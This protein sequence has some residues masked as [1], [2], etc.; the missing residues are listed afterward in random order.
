MPACT[1]GKR[2]R[3][4]HVPLS[5]SVTITLN[6]C[7][8][9]TVCSIFSV[10]TVIIVILPL[11]DL[12]LRAAKPGNRRTQGNP[13]IVSIVD[14]AFR[15]TSYRVD[16]HTNEYCRGNCL[17]VFRIFYHTHHHVVISL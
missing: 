16:R 10:Y 3:V 5:K 17:V 9:A 2:D 13:N 11:V 1:F 8:N 14:S 12:L 4:R 15:G 7:L 6:A